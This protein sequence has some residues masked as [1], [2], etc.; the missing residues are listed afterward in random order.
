MDKK[1]GII[2]PYRDRYNHLISFKSSI[3]SYLK[4]KNIDF[5]LIIVEQDDA[6][7]FNRGKLLNIGF[8][9]AIKLKCDYVAFHDVDMLPIEVDY[10]YS[11][12]PLL[13]ATQRSSFDEF[14]SSVILFPIEYFE[15]INGYSN[16]Y[17]GWGF[18]DD[19]L[20]FR[21]KVNNIPL[22]KKEIKVVSS[23]NA[24]LKF[25]G[26]NAYVE[27][28]YKPKDES[29]IFI[30]F[31][32]QDLVLNHETFDDEFVIFSLPKLD[33]KIS[34]DSYSKYKIVTNDIE[35][36]ILY[37]NSERL[38]PYK[39]N[40]CVT[41]GD[42]KIKLY[43][44]GELVGET[45]YSELKNNDDKNFYLGQTFKGLIYNLAIYNKVLND[46]EVKEISQNKH[47]GLTSFE[48]SDSLKTYYD[49]SFTKNYQLLDLSGN[50]NKG[51]IYSCE[52]IS[53]NIEDSNIIEVPFKRESTFNLLHH[54][55]NGFE[56]GGWKDINT[57]YN[58]L[59][60]SNE[61]SKGYINTKEDGLNNL[62]YKEHSNNKFDNETHIVVKI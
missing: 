43:Q 27:G 10:S 37:I 51:K 38:N 8:K 30:S 9:Q 49:A 20:L 2:V 53:C 25:N 45:K 48:S 31:K 14:F 60:F 17:W 40:L 21:C 1:L 47:F 56:N 61:V 54:N 3:S 35:E 46:D 36:N 39:T 6:K 29:T 4:S 18:E 11:D 13:L 52:I 16:E 12:T 32:P 57:R 44:D 34:Y 5:E 62:H 19:D 42:N 59:K 15:K 55:N 41:I 26:Y 58:Q 22:D 28:L 50:G 23:H 33:L 24:A 7:L